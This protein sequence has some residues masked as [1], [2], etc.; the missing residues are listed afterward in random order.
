MNH[1]RMP[2]HRRRL[3]ALVAGAAAIAAIVAPAAAD[4]GT[5]EGQ[6]KVMTRNLY[7]G[8][9]LSPALAASN[10]TELAIAAQNIWNTVHNTNFPD[11][12]K[13]LAKEIAKNKPDLVGLQE[14]AL[15][16]GDFKGTGPDG[17][18]TPATTVEFD[19]LALLMK[20]LKEQG[21]NYRVVQKQNEFD[22]EIPLSG[23]NPFDGRLTMRDVIL[24]K[25][26]AGVKTKLED[27]DN[28]STNHSLNVQVG[29][30]SGLPVT[31]KRGWEYTQANVRGT[32]FRFLN[33]HLEAFGSPTIRENQAKD[34]VQTFNPGAGA[35]SYGPATE[36][37][38]GMPVVAV[39]DFN[40]DDDTVSGGDRLAYNALVAGGLN[41]LSTGATAPGADSSC[42]L[43]DE[44]LRKSFIDGWF[45]F[46]HQVDHVFTTS[47]DVDPVST[48]VVGKQDEPLD[49][50]GMWPSDHAGLVTTMQ[51]PTP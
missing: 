5:P 27:S 38:A 48:K 12:A 41:E 24:A 6:V 44:T 11:R 21:A 39:G 18:V 28:Y 3:A 4:A 42:C 37:S 22:A 32:E 51:F 47:G 50:I 23:G 19:F 1:A 49:R 43:D 15:W 30:P 33:T 35:F 17:P 14:V 36:G 34:L 46:D 9:D 20:Q 40:S 10:T 31:V 29:G 45:D 7:L 16:R 26:K 25:N 13:E 8:A 2:S